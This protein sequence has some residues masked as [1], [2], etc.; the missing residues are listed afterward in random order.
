M[1]DFWTKSHNNVIYVSW[2][3]LTKCESQT[4]NGMLCWDTPRRSFNPRVSLL[5]PPSTEDFGFEEWFHKCPEASLLV[6]D[7]WNPCVFFFFFFL[8]IWFCTSQGGFILWMVS[9]KTQGFIL[10][11][12]PHI[13]ATFSWIHQYG[14][15][16]LCG[17]LRLSHLVLISTVKL[18]VK[19]FNDLTTCRQVDF[20]LNVPLVPLFH[21]PF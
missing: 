19:N 6:M 2:S 16:Y 1:I 12:I 11:V 20:T 3:T 21:Y 5:K 15:R 9:R 17:K 8:E 14:I 13:L 7:L 10:G 4:H 18:S